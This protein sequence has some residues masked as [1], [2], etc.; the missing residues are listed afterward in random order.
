MLTATNENRGDQEEPENYTG[1]V[2]AVPS[3]LSLSIKP[4]ID[5]TR[6]PSLVRF[7]NLEIS[8]ASEGEEPRRPVNVSRVD[9]REGMSV[10]REKRAPSS[11]ACLDVRP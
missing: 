4:V 7:N 8:T 1:A 10:N 3:L 9:G 11:P 6:L 2:F 5:V